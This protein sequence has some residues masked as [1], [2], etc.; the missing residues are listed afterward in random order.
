MWAI[1]LRGIDMKYIFPFP[2]EQ[3]PEGS[4]IVIY[5][6]GFI[7]HQYLAQVQEKKCYELLYIVDKNHEKIHSLD[8]VDVFGPQKL[9]CD[10]KYDFVIVASGQYA[11]S[12]CMNLKSLGVPESKIITVFPLKVRSQADCYED[13]IVS[14]IFKLLG[15]YPF[16]YIDVGA[17]DPYKSSNTA[18]L[19]LNGCRGINIEANPDLID[20]LKEERPEDITIN[21]GVGIERGTFS[22]FMFENNIFNTFCKDLAEARV[23]KRGQL[24]D[25]MQIPVKTLTEII[26]SY[27]DG[28]WPDFL[29]IDVEGL[30][31]DILNSC[32]FSNGSPIVVCAEIGRAEDMKLFEQKGYVA[33]HKTLGNIVYVRKDIVNQA[34]NI[35]GEGF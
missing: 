30:D 33:F 14:T 6:A 35:L 19:Y 18:Y 25:V 7:G 13:Y 2:F 11:D 9:L 29:Q 24:V 21:C 17:N 20:F 31:F 5:G 28:K 10:T 12:I 22:F 1:S 15:K 32:D 26:D 34:L 23:E 27:A 3:I 8:G 4:A 16:S